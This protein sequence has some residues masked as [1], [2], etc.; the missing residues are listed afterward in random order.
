MKVLW[1]IILSSLYLLYPIKLLSY[2]DSGIVINEVQPKGDGSPQ[3]PDWI[4]LYNKATQP[5]NIAY[6][7]IT[8]QNDEDWDDVD[9]N[10]ITWKNGQ[11]YNDTSYP[12]CRNFGGSDCLYMIPYDPATTSD[13]DPENDYTLLV[14]PDCYVVIYNTSGNNDYSCDG[15]GVIRLYM[16]MD[17]QD[18]LVEDGDDV[19]LIQWFY[20][21]AYDDSGNPTEKGYIWLVV[22]YFDWNPG[23]VSTYNE[24]PNHCGAIKNGIFYEYPDF[25]AHFDTWGDVSDQC[26][27][28]WLYYYYGI[29]YLPY[30][31]PVSYS[32]HKMDPD[33]DE[34][35]SSYGRVPNGYDSDQTSD[36]QVVEETPGTT[37]V[38]IEYMKAYYK[39]G[40]TI[41][42]WRSAHEVGVVGYNVY[43]GTYGKF[44]RLNREIIYSKGDNS[45]YSFT[46]EGKVEI[47]RLEIVE[48]GNHSY[49]FKPLRVIDEAINSDKN[50]QPERLIPCATDSSKS[51]GCSEG[52]ADSPE[53]FL[54]LFLFLPYFFRVLSGLRFR[55]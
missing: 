22:D 14:D 2:I 54:I 45:T 41:I 33:T 25:A 50:Y 7:I 31:F 1:Y 39:D 47:V 32:S 48:Y 16:G 44:H 40:V 49:F 21:E 46:Y 55:A 5:V 6:W 10:L 51:P 11:D 35:H 17:N 53:I 42:K 37:D 18:I 29:Y 27:I 20:Y 26:D 12:V 24:H 15:D 28:N 19:S 52:G 34:L 4:E 3:N 9:N 30:N 43:G 23:N 8:N 36:W 38:E 13:S